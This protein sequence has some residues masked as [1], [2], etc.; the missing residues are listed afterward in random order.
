MDA[1]TPV[2]IFEKKK[3][4]Q[5]CCVH[6]KSTCLA[7]N[8]AFLYKCTVINIPEPV[9]RCLTAQLSSR[10]KHMTDNSFHFKEANQ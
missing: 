10:K 5:R 4:Y 3:L 9:G 1:P 8:L 2:F 6:T 7:K